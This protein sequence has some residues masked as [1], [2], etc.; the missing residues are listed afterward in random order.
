MATRAAE[1][2][3]WSDAT[4]AQLLTILRA[5]AADGLALD[6][7]TAVAWRV[8]A[9]DGLEFAAALATIMRWV[10][11]VSDEWGVRGV[12]AFLL[13]NGIVRIELAMMKASVAFEIAM[14]RADVA[15]K[16]PAVVIEPHGLMD[17]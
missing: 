6:E 11:A 1:G 16:Q 5:I 2:L 17:R 4:V 7:G 8:T 13:P 3:A 10:A 15:L 14:P 12:A 9:R